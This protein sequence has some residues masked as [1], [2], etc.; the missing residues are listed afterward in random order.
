MAQLHRRDR[1]RPEVPRARP[2]GTRAVTTPR[3]RTPSAPWASSGSGPRN[4]DIDPD[5]IGILGFSAGGHLAAT[6]SNQ[7]FRSGPIPAVDDADEVELPARLHPADL[8]GLPGRAQGGA[9]VAPEVKVTTETPPTF[10]VQTEDDGVPVEC[11][12]F[13]YLALKNAKVP[14]EMHLYPVGGHGYGLRPSA[15]TV[16]IGPSAPSSGCAPPA[17]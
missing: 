16:S 10:L 4:G 14:G 15:H 12:L 3:C 7:N 5:R 6:L 9:D 17:C 1:H 13:Y 2:Q 8:P 11:S